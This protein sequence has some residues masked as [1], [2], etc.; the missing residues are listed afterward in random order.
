MWL[1]EQIEQ[2][3]LRQRAYASDATS[4]VLY[5]NLDQRR[6][7]VQQEMTQLLHSFL[8]GEISVK[9]FNASFQQ[10][11]QVEWNVFGLRGTSGGMFFN[12]LVK[13]IPDEPLLARHLRSALT[14]PKDTHDGQRR[15]HSFVEFLGKM[16]SRQYVTRGQL[17]PARVPFFSAPGG[18]SK[19]I[20]AG[21]FFMLRRIPF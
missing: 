19:I 16:I 11:M 3:R 5:Q 4:V 14:L 6:S 10:K 18:T 12:R 7:A 20:S 8:Q 17:Q 9:A 13:Y 1:P 2:W 21:L 15:M